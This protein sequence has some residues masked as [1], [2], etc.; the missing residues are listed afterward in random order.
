MADLCRR[1]PTLL[2]GL[3]DRCR[4]D[5]ERAM[6]GRTLNWSG[7]GGHQRLYVAAA[8]LMRLA[9]A[10]NGA[11][12][13]IDDLHEADEASLRLLHYLA[14][15]GMGERFVLLLCHRRQPVTEVFE[16]MR[17]SLVS[18]GAAAD[19]PL[20]PLTLDETA[21]LVASVRPGLSADAVAQIWDY[22]GGVPFAI[23][24]GARL[25]D[26]DGARV[27]GPGA[28]VLSLLDP[29]VRA[30]L[31]RVA[32]TGST[33]DTDEFVALAG[34]PEDEAFDCLD[35]VL[36]AMVI[37]RTRTGF[38]FRHQLVRDALLDGVPEHRQRQL[39]RACAQ[40][41]DR[42]G[43]SP[44]RVGH[45]LLAAGDPA[46]AVPFVLRAA[47]TEAAIGAY[48]D[49]LAHI[50]SIRAAATGPDLARALALRADLLAASAD[51]R[52]ATAYRQAID[53]ASPEQRRLLQARLARMVAFAGDLDTAES[54]LTRLDLDG[55]AADPTI[56]LARGTVAY[57]RGDLEAA[58]EVT[59]RARGLVANSETDWQVL[60]LVSL[61]GLLAH[62]RGEWHQQLMIE[63]RRTLNDPALATAVF[64]SHLC[65]AEYLLYGPTPYADVIRL[66]GGLRDSANRAGAIRAVA[67]ATALIGEAALLAD[68]LD[69]AE[70]ELRDSV[71][72][73]R[74]IGAPAGE[75]HS[76]Q[77]LAEVL[78]A[79]G[80]AGGANRLLNRALPLA[81]WSNLAMHLLHRIFGTMIAAADG[82]HSARAIVDQA[83]A[84]L[85]TTD[86]CFF[87]EVMLAVPA[88]IACAD[89]GDVDDARMYIADAERSA[90]LW[91]GTAWQ[92]AILEARAHLA[93]AE[94]D[95]PH[96][97]RLLA[98]AAAIFEEAGQP[99]DAA[100]C[101]V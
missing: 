74:E 93:R 43:A 85:S 83:R 54:L 99:R 62:N 17:S 47:E 36:A 45:H 4:D 82:A 65:V 77:R 3:D 68:D 90:D 100:R 7:D 46:S 48:R 79:R 30:V 91:Q 57:F 23:V 2:D 29:G 61:Q 11:L 66:A 39:H 34:L 6:S 49:A 73:H 52:A 92:A 88:A 33:F 51:A 95:E 96:A 16:H 72:L 40:R 60:D 31:E 94:A 69:L 50:D 20:V 12:L 19:V 78:L 13:S 42:L 24:E 38:R 101:R 18:R 80:D 10:G 98:D 58:R 27:G 9:S 21:M 70:R 84:T 64:D 59:N 55:G 26:P 71:D 89:V 87:C 37:E 63:L 56:M 32:V 25:A 97:Q 44:A 86:T 8:E 35:A 28:A 15:S 41:L 53:V 22:S 81:R 1:H 5:I 14:R 67:F 76:L 75:A